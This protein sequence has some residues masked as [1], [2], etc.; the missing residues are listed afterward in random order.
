MSS[1]R[2]LPIATSVV[3]VEWLSATLV[4][5]VVASDELARFGPPVYADSYVKALFLHP[6]VD[7]PRPINPAALREQLP[8]EHLPRMRTYTVRAFDPE[9]NELTLDF[10]VHGDSGIAGPW[11]AAAKPGDELHIIGPGGAYN[12]DPAAEWHLLVGDESALPAIAVAAE[13]IPADVA[14]TTYVEV[15]GPKDEI[16]L[17]RPVVWLHRGDEP[18]GSKLVDAVRGWQQPAGTGQ[19][20]VHG[21]AGVVKEL[22]R[23]LRLDRG[24]P[25][26]QLSI[27][28]YWRIGV[29]DEGWRQVKREWNREVE[30]AEAGVA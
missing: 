1:P 27:S 26:D 22:R 21:E 16:D 29:D 25:L 28:G 6:D 30:E 2:P 20:F 12:P 5:V 17:A 7:Y 4:R 19:A 8:A 10:V 11:A 24:L 13:R 18:V 14:V 3:R 9:R 23:H 15:H